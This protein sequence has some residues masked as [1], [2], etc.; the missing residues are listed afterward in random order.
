VRGWSPEAIAEAA[1][2]RPSALRGRRIE[3]PGPVLVSDDCYNASP[4]S[5]RAALDDL[6]AS[7]PARRAAVLGDAGEHH[8]TAGAAAAAELVAPGDPGPRAAAGA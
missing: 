2:V 3:R 7:A 6:A 1:G 8:A 5:M 4:M